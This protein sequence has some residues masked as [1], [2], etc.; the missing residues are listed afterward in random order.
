MKYTHN[1]KREEYNE[2]IGEALFE[3]DFL[4]VHTDS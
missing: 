4:S 3:I 1:Q 2:C